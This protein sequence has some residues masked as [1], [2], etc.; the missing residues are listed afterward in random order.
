MHS[1][2]AETPPIQLPRWS[3]LVWPKEHGSWSLALEPVALGLIAA[4]S[5]GGIALGMAVMAGFFAR[6]P[7]KIAVGD[8][9][10]ARREIG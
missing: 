3:D 5:L 4:P 6:R 8:R 10:P 1:T 9:N 7:L 2:M